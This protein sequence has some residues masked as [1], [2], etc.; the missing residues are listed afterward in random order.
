MAV[1]EYPMDSVSSS[2]PRPQE[3]TV[4]TEKFSGGATKYDDGGVDAAMQ[5]GGNGVKVWRLNYPK[6]SLVHAAILDAHVAS[7]KWMEDEGMSAFTFN[8]RERSDIGAT[9][10]SGVRY[11]KYEVGHSKTHIQ[12]REIELTKFP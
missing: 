1:A 7:A 5:H 2:N 11:T 12:S 6:L 9:L 8:F 10:Y 4:L 3:F